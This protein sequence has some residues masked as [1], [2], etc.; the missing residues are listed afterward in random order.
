MRIASVIVLC[1]NIS[2]NAMKTPV[3][4][5]YALIGI[6]P[7]QVKNIHY[8]SPVIYIHYASGSVES[9][10]MHFIA[11]SKGITFAQLDQILLTL[12]P[13]E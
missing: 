4:D 8:D 11:N 1:Y 5:V 13:V 3:I 6:E 12:Y 7:E 9:M 2:H 10:N